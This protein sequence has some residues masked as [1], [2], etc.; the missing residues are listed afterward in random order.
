MALTTAIEGIQDKLG[1]TGAAH[2][3]VDRKLDDA[4]ADSF[5]ASDP[6]ALSMPHDREELNLHRTISPSTMWL[7]GGGLLAIIALIALRR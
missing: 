2:R 1:T 3:A 7:V 6:V 4:V 5:P